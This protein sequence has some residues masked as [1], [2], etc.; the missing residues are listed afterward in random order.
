ME[1]RVKD[2]AYYALLARIQELFELPSG[3]EAAQDWSE[4][5]MRPDHFTQFV[6]AYEQVRHTDV[7][8]DR[9]LADLIIDNFCYAW[10]DS[11]FHAHV[12]VQ[13][14]METFVQRYH[15]RLG[16][17]ECLRSL[18][19]IEDRPGDE[20]PEARWL[21]ECWSR[22]TGEPLQNLLTFDFVAAVGDFRCLRTDSPPA[23]PDPV[24][25]S[26]FLG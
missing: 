12:G 14:A 13:H 16:V 25:N 23:L 10:R 11:G 5:A 4:H 2:A 19:I 26:G 1:T 22:L 15:R 8:I 6:E 3:F 20:Y 9:S 17:R 7:W 21:R 24:A 18:A